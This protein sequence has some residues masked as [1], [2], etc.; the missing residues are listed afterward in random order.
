[1]ADKAQ[2][3]ATDT[4]FEKKFKKRFGTPDDPKDPPII[5][6]YQEQKIKIKKLARVNLAQK[7]DLAR[8]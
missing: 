2:K 7:K 8:L 3:S 6:L 5:D 1:M 4:E